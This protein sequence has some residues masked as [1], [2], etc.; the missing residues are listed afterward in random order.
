MIV[1]N[2]NL[3]RA[4]PHREDVIFFAS[5]VSDS[6]CTDQAEFNREKHLL[7][8][9][10]DPQDTR[11][12]FYFSSLSV[13]F[14]NTP[15][16]KH[17]REMEEMIRKHWPNYVILRIGNLEGDTN[18]NTFINYLRAHPEATILDEYRYL[19]DTGTLWM[20]C[21]VL[22]SIG[23]HELTATSHIKKVIDYVR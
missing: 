16:L 21:N 4:C 7:S 13:N 3:A 17:K 2:G 23:K 20:L 8:A 10:F 12:L 9:Y 6:G 15:Y 18:P 22:P 11:A 14:G 1:G 19:I 5:G